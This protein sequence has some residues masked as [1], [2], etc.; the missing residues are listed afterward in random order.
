MSGTFLTPYEI[1]RKALADFGVQMSESGLTARLRELRRSNLQVECHRRSETK[2]FEYRIV[3]CVPVGT[4]FSLLESLPWTNVP[5]EVL[6][7]DR[8]FEGLA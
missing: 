6:M 2:S 8:D 4:Q 3:I 7:S 1:Q 5:K